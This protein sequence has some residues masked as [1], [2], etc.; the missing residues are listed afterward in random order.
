LSIAETTT[1]TE[2]EGSREAAL[3]YHEFP[4]PQKTASA[5]VGF[6]AIADI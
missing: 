4:T 1:Q 5:Y 3:N 6:R 2:K